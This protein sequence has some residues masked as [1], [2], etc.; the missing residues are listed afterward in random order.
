M[1][2]PS[3]NSTLHNHITA[4]KKGDLP[5]ENAFQCVSR[6]ILDRDIEKV[7]VNGKTTF[8]FKIFRE[9]KKHIIGMYDEINSFV[10]FV[11]GC[12]P[13]RLLV[14]DGVCSGRRAGQRQDLS[15]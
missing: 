2:A 14:G 6:M 9:G 15:G 1:P 4:V 8:D 5:F 10:S 11:K 12:G 13:G 3:N 7:V